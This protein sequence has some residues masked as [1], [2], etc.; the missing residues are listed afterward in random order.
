MVPVGTWSRS[1][2][3][4][5]V[6]GELLGDLVGLRHDAVEDFERDGHQAGVRDPGAVVAVGG[7]ALLVGADAGDG[8]ARWRRGRT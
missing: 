2:A 8:A 3:V 5:C 1:A 6:V 4:A 7:L